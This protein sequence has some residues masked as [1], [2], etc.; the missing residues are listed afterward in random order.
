[1]IDIMEIHQRRNSLMYKLSKRGAISLFCWFI[2][3][4]AFR[5]VAWPSTPDDVTAGWL[6]AILFGIAGAVSGMLAVKYQKR[7][8]PLNAEPHRALALILQAWT[9]GLD[10]PQDK[11]SAPSPDSG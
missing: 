8:S 3:A 9:L 2:A 4:Y 6:L 11:E 5:H 1:M 10:E 7:L